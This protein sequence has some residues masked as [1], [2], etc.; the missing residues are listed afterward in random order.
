MIFYNIPSR[1]VIDIEPETIARLAEIPNVRAVKQAKP[2]STQARH[3]VDVRAGPL[4][5]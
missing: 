3:V 4:R 5:R 2:T 1:V